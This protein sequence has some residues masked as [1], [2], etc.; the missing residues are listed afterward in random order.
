MQSRLGSLIEALVNVAVGFVISLISQL[1]IFYAY[2]IKLSLASNVMITVW[3]TVISIIRSY[4]LRRAFNS[5]HNK[6][7]KNE[8]N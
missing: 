5:Y 7:N 2:D 1:V 6:E 4:A 8:R 3:F